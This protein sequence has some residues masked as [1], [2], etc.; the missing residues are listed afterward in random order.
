MKLEDKMKEMIEITK[1][2]NCEETHH[3]IEDKNYKFIIKLINKQVKKEERKIR[4][5][6]KELK[7]EAGE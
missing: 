2:M 3:T 6:K 7:K 4:N 1:Q 5:L